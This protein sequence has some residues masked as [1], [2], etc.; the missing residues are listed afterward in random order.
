MK[1][2]ITKLPVLEAVVGFFIVVLAVTFLG[3][4]AST[5]SDDEE[6]GT[7]AASETPPP[8]GDGNGL[9]VTL[10]DNSFNPDALTVPAGQS[11]TIN[12]T[13]EG[14]AIHNMR[15]AGADNEFDNDDDA[16]SDPE[17]I[18]G[19]QDAVINWDSPAQPGE[20]DFRC[21]FH[22]TEMT[23]TITVQ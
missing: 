21:D 4:F 15:I 14:A 12:I 5:R 9:A 16:V 22:P 6:A 13:N 23:G 1:V 17:I 10:E 3:A 19:G 20:I 11:V 8:S 7:P 2:D 18:P